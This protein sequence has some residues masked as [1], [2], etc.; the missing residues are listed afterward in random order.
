MNKH[1][2]GWRCSNPPPEKPAKPWHTAAIL[3]VILLAYGVAGSS[4]FDESLRTDVAEQLA[5][6]RAARAGLCPGTAG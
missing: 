5:A 3:G 2:K 1:D 6:H 4:D